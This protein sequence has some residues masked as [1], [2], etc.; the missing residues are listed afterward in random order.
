MA[1]SGCRRSSTSSSCF[2]RAHGGLLT[3]PVRTS[4]RRDVQIC[5]DAANVVRYEQR[6]SSVF[7]VKKNTHA[8]LSGRE[9]PSKKM[10]CPKCYLCALTHVLH[11]GQRL[12]HGQCRVGVERPGLAGTGPR[13]RPACSAASAT[14]CTSPGRVYERVRASKNVGKILN[15]LFTHRRESCVAVTRKVH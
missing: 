11:A 10:C 15:W 12:R 1:R 14:P 4:L 2:L 13:R 7:Y 5:A 8:L 9:R 3:H 6:K